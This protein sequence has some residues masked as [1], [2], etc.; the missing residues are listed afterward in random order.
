MTTLTYTLLSL[1]VLSLWLPWRFWL[2]RP[3]EAWHLLLA[4]A[5]VCALIAGVLQPIGLVSIAI[6]LAACV[7][8]GRARPRSAPHLVSGVV[9]FV[10]SL[11]LIAHVAPGFSNLRIQSGVVISPGAVPYTQYLNF[12][13]ALVGICLIGILHPRLTM[14]MEWEAMAKRAIPWAGAAIGVLMSW[15][16]LL[17]Y[18]R[19][20]LKIPPQFALWVLANLLYTCTAEEAFFRGFVQRTLEGD[21]IADGRNA[22]PDPHPPPDSDSGS[23]HIKPNVGLL[24][25]GCL[26]GLAHYAG[27]P[28]YVA[29]ATVAGL[30]YGAVYSDTRS[31]ESSILTHF[32]VNLTHILFFTYPALAL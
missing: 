10:I 5:I 1:T 7:A 25:A 18:V 13:K 16:A 32:A 24:V 12:D 4:L 14:R 3:V 6:L 31:I 21:A 8:F 28:M 26:F 30:T 23:G 2:P 19:V 15:S 22:G 29:L 20:D 17:G 9:L 27:G 11:M